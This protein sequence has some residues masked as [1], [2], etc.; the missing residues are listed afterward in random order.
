M[1]RMLRSIDTKFVALPS[2]PHKP[3]PGRTRSNFKSSFAQTCDLLDRELCML[4]ARHVIIQFDCNESE[5]TLD[6]RHRAKARLRSPGVI[7]SFESKVGPLAYPCDNF[8][9]WH[10]NLRAIALS[11]EALRKVDRYG[12]T[13]GAEQYRGWK[14]LT[15]RGDAEFPNADAAAVFLAR[16]GGGGRAT[17]GT[18]MSDFDVCKSAY[19]HAAATNH[20][21]RGGDPGLFS[22]ITAAW[23]VLRA[24]HERR[25]VS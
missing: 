24:W 21:D 19:K 2:W 14:R 11:L 10:D 13:K 12:V 18:L 9:D 6:G 25:K 8:T 15:L 20:P 4:N 16:H 17:V 7:L 5:T 3:T 23:E 22:R 1:G